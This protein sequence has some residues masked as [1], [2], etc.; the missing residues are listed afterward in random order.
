MKKLATVLLVLSFVVISSHLYY[1]FRTIYGVDVHEM[2]VSTQSLTER[3]QYH[4]SIQLLISDLDPD[5]LKYLINADCGGGS[6]C[7][8]HGKTLV[9]VLIKVGDHSFSKIIP[10]LHKEESERLLSLLSAGYEYGGFPEWSDLKGQFPLT[11][12]T[13]DEKV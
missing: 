2:A 5:A 8:D 7:Y 13:F 4:R 6:G 12:R 1:V 11:F 9:Q 10:K 3:Y